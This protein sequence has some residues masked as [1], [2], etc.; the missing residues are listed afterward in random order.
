MAIMLIIIEFDLQLPL[1]VRKIIPISQQ[2]EEK[3]SSKALKPKM[4]FLK[5][6][7]GHF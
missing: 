3:S 6:H 1:W 4:P 7:E 5:F 2:N